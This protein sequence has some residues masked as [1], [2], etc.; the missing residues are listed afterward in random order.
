MIVLEEKESKKL[1]VLFY[2][3]GGYF[4]IAGADDMLAGPDFFLEHEVIVVTSNYRLGLLGFMSL[5][6][7]EY[8]GNMG[9]KDQ[10]LAMKWVYENI[11]A[12]GGDNQKITLGG[13]SA[14]ILHD[15]NKKKQ[16]MKKN[17]SNKRLMNFLLN[18]RL[19]IYWVP[20]A[21]R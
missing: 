17:Y 19:N 9:L 6:T 8:S 2:I 16:I 12:F 11:E 13:I 3:Q 10:Q 4:A 18:L 1:P 5:G 14:G 21:E 15:S 20:Y 7:P